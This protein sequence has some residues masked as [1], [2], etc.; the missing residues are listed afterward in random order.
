MGAAHCMH[1]LRCDG[2]S[3][4][5]LLLISGALDAGLWAKAAGSAPGAC[6]K[7]LVFLAHGED[8]ETIPEMVIHRGIAAVEGLAG[9]TVSEISL[10]THFHEGGH[11]I[12]EGTVEAIAMWA[13]GSA[14]ARLP[15]AHLVTEKELQD[16]TT[17]A[18]EITPA[19]EDA[20]ELSK[21]ERVKLEAMKNSDLKKL[22]RS[23][24]V[25]DD[26]LDGA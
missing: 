11:E 22:A 5:A 3:A 15:G 26:D 13:Q 16:E 4:S 6:E 2:I 24:G 9:N 7:L 20:D 10:D 8:H 17:P 1:A 23:T 12:G 19:N 14:I 18:D 21:A 25:S